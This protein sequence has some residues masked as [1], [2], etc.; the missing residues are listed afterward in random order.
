MRSNCE[1]NGE[2]KIKLENNGKRRY[3]TLWCLLWF[4]DGRHDINIV[5]GERVNPAV[6]SLSRKNTVTILRCYQENLDVL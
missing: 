3:C 4:L 5:V 6:Y 2:L 1:Q